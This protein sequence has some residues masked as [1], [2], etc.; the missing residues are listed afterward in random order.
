MTSESL[1]GLWGGFRKWEEEWARGIASLGQGS[2]IGWALVICWRNLNCL[3]DE[4]LG[5]QLVSTEQ[6]S[7]E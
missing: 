3:S 5:R 2:A 1:S 4:Q 6:M 7:A